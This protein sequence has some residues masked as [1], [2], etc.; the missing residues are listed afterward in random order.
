[1]T[2]QL[3]KQTDVHSNNLFGWRFSFFSLGVIVVTLA[4]ALI[5]GEPDK[6]NALTD[7]PLPTDTLIINK[8]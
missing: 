5:L 4:A 7:E 1:M 8:K 2:E 3:H 6:N